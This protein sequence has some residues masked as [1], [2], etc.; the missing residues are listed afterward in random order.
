MLETTTVD[1]QAVF[2]LMIL[3]SPS[4][5][6]TAVTSRTV[7]LCTP[8]PV[9]AFTVER[10]VLCAAVQS[11]FMFRSA[12][13]VCD[14]TANCRPGVN[15]TAFPVL[16]VKH[17]DTKEESFQLLVAQEH[18]HTQKCRLVSFV[19][20]FLRSLFSPIS[21]SV[22]PPR[23]HCL[24]V[25]TERLR[26]AWRQTFPSAYS[27]TTRRQEKASHRHEATRTVHIQRRETAYKSNTYAVHK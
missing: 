11:L 3:A 18:T 14:Y 22:L 1:Y 12:P 6:C 4:K 25:T 24:T 13:T 19:C 8:L 10:S 7:R 27:K 16:R 20:P 5:L 15:T 21:V 9:R 26:D 2:V 23:R 17:E